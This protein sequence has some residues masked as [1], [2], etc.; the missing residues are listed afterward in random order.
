MHVYR[1]DLDRTYLDTEIH[2]MRGLVR[3]AFE[4]AS[5]KR[6]VPG[7]AALLRGL[8]ARDPEARV[9][10][11]SGSPI[12]MREVLLQKLALDGV[13]VDRLILKDNLGNIRRGRLRAVRGQIGFKLPHLLEDRIDLPL[14][15]EE[16]LF[17]DDSEADALI[18]STYA[19]VLAGEIGIDQLVAILKAGDAYPDMVDRAVGAAKTLARSDAVREIFIRVDRGIPVGVYR[20]LGS[21]VRPVFAWLQAAMV[22]WVRGALEDASLVNVMDSIS[23]T[24]GLV[25]LISDAAR[26][27]LVQSDD[28]KRMIDIPNLR[29]RA[30][31]IQGALDRLGPSP[32]PPPPATP[33]DYLGFLAAVRR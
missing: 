26:R 5:D 7:A 18:Y 29:E 28:I 21:R 20:L 31:G 25:G 23:S 30:P 12:Q 3:A 6:T 19:A 13:R 10:I 15:T 22:L 11:L 17:G 9:H 4:D 32:L 27:G 24:E 1:W 14:D 33:P 8:C 16:T 2:S